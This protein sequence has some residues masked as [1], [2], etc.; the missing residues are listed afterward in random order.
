MLRPREA[1]ADKAAYEE[2]AKKLAGLFIKNF[3]T[4]AGGASAEV[5]AAAPRS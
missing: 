4:Y 5:K 1:W 3:E 2:T